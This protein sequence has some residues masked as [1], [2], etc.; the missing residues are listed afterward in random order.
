ME[1]LDGNAIAGRLEEIFGRDMTTA[2]GTCASC[3][4]VGQVA[5]LAVYLQ[6][7]GVVCR[8]RSCG[9]I[10]MVVTAIRGVNCLDFRGLADLRMP[11]S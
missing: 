11:P 6:A 10:L 8:C 1:T 3:G 5:E 4:A 9:S 7:P 2:T